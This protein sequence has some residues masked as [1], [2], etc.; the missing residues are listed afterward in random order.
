MENSR[1]KIICSELDLFIKWGFVLSSTLSNKVTQLDRDY[2]GY[3]IFSKVLCH[4]ISLRRIIPTGLN[5]EQNSQSELWDLASACAL[6]RAL[7][8]SFDALFYQA[9][10]E[11]EDSERE[12]RLYLWD[13]HAEERRL[14][15]LDLIGLKAPEVESLKMEVESLRKKVIDHKYFKELKKDHKGKINKGNSPDY[16]LSH[17]ERNERA[18]INHDYYNS[19]IIFLSAYVHT[20]PFAIKQLKE[21]RAGDAESLR[22]MSMPIQY[23]LGFLAKSIEGMHSIF[24]TRLPNKPDNVSD[25]CEIWSGILEKG[26]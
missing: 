11:I 25:L 23:A 26:I 4:A 19:C 16:Y 20:F 10:E 13:L 14:K 24:E 8:E 3:C 17:K 5:P 21:F 22:L 18:S 1:Y 12:F 9:I 2:Y 7:I 15:K 6:S